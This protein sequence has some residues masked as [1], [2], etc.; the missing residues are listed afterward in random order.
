MQG[1]GGL[2]QHPPLLQPR[3]KAVWNH[4]IQE[5]MSQSHQILEIMD[6]RNEA[7]QNSSCLGCHDARSPLVPT[8]VPFAPTASSVAVHQVLSW[9]SVPGAQGVFPGQFQ[10]LPGLQTPTPLKTVCPMYAFSRHR[11]PALCHVLFQAP[12]TGQGTDL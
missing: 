12:G 4:R 8:C 6:L 1:K 7:S 10:L 3:G 2:L 9:A 11:V 5:M